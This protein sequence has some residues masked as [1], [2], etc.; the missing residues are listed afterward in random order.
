MAKLVTFAWSNNAINSMTMACCDKDGAM[1]MR[2]WCDSAISMVRFWWRVGRQRRSDV[3]SCHRHHVTAP[4]RYRLFTHGL[5]ARELASDMNIH[6]AQD[7]IHYLTILSLFWMC[8]WKLM[9]LLSYLLFRIPSIG[10]RGW[11]WGFGGLD[12]IS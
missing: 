5:F 8:V 12:I 10:W 7:I 2:R 9:C 11:G 1:T 6:D 4:L 3:L